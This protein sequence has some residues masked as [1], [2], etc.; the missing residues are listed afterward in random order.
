MSKELREILERSRRLEIRT[1]KLCLALGVDPH[2][3]QGSLVSHEGLRLVAV[4]NQPTI[5]TTTASVSLFQ[6]KDFADQ[7]GLVG[8]VPVMLGAE[9]WLTLHLS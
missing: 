8:D 2:K 7:E 1:T 9:Q 5:H 6:L 4:D 3:S